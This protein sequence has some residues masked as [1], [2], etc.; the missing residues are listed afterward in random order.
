MALVREYALEYEEV[1]LPLRIRTRGLLLV[2]SALSPG[3]AVVVLVVRVDVKPPQLG[4]LLGRLG[5]HLEDGA[6]LLKRHDF[7]LMTGL[8]EFLAADDLLDVLANQATPTEAAA[9]A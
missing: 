8:D 1:L 7:W 6:V 2:D 3:V 9:A 4:V 5:G